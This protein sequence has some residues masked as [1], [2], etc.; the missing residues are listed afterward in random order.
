MSEFE[1]PKEVLAEA[2]KTVIA[3]NEAGNP[4]YYAGFDYIARWMREECLSL[5]RKNL[6][7]TLPAD[8]ADVLRLVEG[9]EAGVNAIK[10]IGTTP[11]PPCHHQWVDAR[12][13]AVEAGEL[14]VK[15]HAI[16]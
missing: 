15:C 5:I 11:E 9:I 2:Y 14:C 6:P 16:R 10:L 12:N 1:I 4:P 8:N 3:A 13:E 7:E